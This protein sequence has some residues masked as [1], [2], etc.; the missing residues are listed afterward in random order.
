MSKMWLWLCGGILFLNPMTA[1]VGLAQPD[2]RA[3]ERSRVTPTDLPP[4]EALVV[5]LY[6]KAVPAVVSVYGVTEE[7]EGDVLVT[8]RSVGSGVAL[9]DGLVLTA[10]HVVQGKER[11]EIRGHDG[12]ERLATLISVDAESDLALVH[13]PMPGP[14][15]RSADLGDS[16]Q[17]AV[18]QRV[19]V[20]G[21]PF[22]L[23]NSLSVGRISGFR[24]GGVEGGDTAEFI[25]T[26]AAISS[27]NSGGPVFDSA[28]RVI[29]I[30]SRFWSVS[31]GSEGIG[32]AA[33]INTALDV[34]RLDPDQ[35][36]LRAGEPLP[37]R[38]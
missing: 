36:S 10:A 38:D 8:T 30:A 25:Q 16:D 35:I 9:P 20:I 15:W 26:D 32:F 3:S 12:V 22:G 4:E 5:S 14:S 13:V 34:F 11:L 19:V 29:G 2:F 23:E 6:S 27:G 33:A 7:M 37:T 24:Q 1:S 21:S 28:G 18:G 31:G 17:L